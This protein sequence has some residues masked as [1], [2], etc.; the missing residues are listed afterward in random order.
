MPIGGIQMNPSSVQEN[1]HC[2]LKA[3][4]LFDSR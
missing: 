3:L 2:G 4:C 1:V